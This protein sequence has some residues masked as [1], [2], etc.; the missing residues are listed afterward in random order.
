MQTLITS[1][2][3]S[4]IKRALKTAKGCEIKVSSRPTIL[5]RP[6]KGGETGTWWLR[7]GKSYI[8]LGIYPAVSTNVIKERLPHIL[9]EL[10]MN[11]DATVEIGSF[12]KVGDLL[13]WYRER[14]LSDRELS[15]KRKATLKSVINKHLIPMLGNKSI[16]ELNHACVDDNL[17]WSLQSEYSLSNVRLIFSALKA[18]FKLAFKQNRIETNPLSAL[19]FTDFIQKRIHPK[20]AQIRA[21]DIPVILY[22]L[23]DCHYSTRM[24]ILMMLM[25]G[26][27]IGETRQAK[28][29]HIDDSYWLLPAEHTKTKQAHRLP[30]TPVSKALLD[31]YR[32]TQKAKGYTGQFLFPNGVRSGQ[33]V[34]AS[35]ASTQIKSFSSGKW[36]AHDLRKVART[37]WADL[38]VDYMVGEMLLNH[39]L[40]KLDKTY[41]HTHVE[42]KMKEALEDYHCW[43]NSEVLL[44]ISQDQSAES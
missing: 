6:H 18:A 1:F 10:A 29:S 13:T 37:V 24:L 23:V 28:W 44:R 7:K 33:C 2:S 19:Q 34:S 39:A 11:T 26:T 21:T 41:I 43:L 17:I 16:N 38:G 35:T 9:L 5:L 27:R 31:L 12:Q 14:S 30:L 8:R 25:F 3:E 20:D 36:S 42:H 15:K 22:S 40:S 4:S 32:E